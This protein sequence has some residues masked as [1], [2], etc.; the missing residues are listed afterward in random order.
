IARFAQRSS[1]LR[2]RS[3][4][5]VGSMFQRIDQPDEEPIMESRPLRW[6]RARMSAAALL[7]VQMAIT[8]FV[9]GAGAPIAPP[10]ARPPD[11]FDPYGPAA[12]G[13]RH[14]RTGD[15]PGEPVARI[16]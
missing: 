3:R 5:A 4:S 12:A 11:P 7:T 10:A 2:G 1:G 13:D 14:R 15:R 6:A 16:A 9:S 8:A